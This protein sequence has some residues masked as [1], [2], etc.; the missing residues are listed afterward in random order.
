MLMWQPIILFGFLLMFAGCA[1]F[2][3]SVSTNCSDQDIKFF[4][5]VDSQWVSCVR[6]RRDP[7]LFVVDD[8]SED[9]FVIRLTEIP[10]E[11]RLLL[12]G[13]YEYHSGYS[14]TYDE[15]CT[16]GSQGHLWINPVEVGKFEISGEIVLQGKRCWP[17]RSFD[18]L[19]IKFEQFAR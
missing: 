3:S 7:S 17:T 16:A 8:E 5:K 15:F 11:R 14:L 12:R 13:E 1:S 4:P 18:K 19:K 6:T 10:N 9:I 2:R